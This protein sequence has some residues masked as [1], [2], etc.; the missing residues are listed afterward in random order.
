MQHHHS[1]PLPNQNSDILQKQP[2]DMPLLRPIS[3]CCAGAGSKVFTSLWE[4]HELCDVDVIVE[5]VKS[6]PCPRNLQPRLHTSH[7]HPA[8]ALVPLPSNSRNPHAPS[9]LPSADFPHTRW[10]LRQ[11]LPTF[12]P[13]SR[14]LSWRAG[15]RRSSSTKSLRMDSR[16]VNSNTNSRTWQVVHAIGC[17]EGGQMQMQ[18]GFRV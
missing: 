3:C 5:G 18:E 10:S 4:N 16:C 6:D 13:C 8:S 2:S 15:P 11:A 14:N 7:S 12:G 1:L 9:P 17:E